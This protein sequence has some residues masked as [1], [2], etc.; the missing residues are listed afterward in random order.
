MAVKVIPKE[1]TLIMRSLII[2]YGISS[3][4]VVFVALVMGYYS[5]YSYVYGNFGNTIIFGLISLGLIIVGTSIII[6]KIAEHEVEITNTPQQLEFWRDVEAVES[7]LMPIDQFLQKHALDVLR[8][9]KFMNEYVSEHTGI[10]AAPIP[11]STESPEITV[12][13]K[14]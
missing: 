9:A 10:P 11:Q 5:T 2:K 3:G 14:P 1:A 13:S 4:I 6:Y 12:Q 7:K 8:L